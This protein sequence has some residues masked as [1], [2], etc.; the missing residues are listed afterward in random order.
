MEYFIYIFGIAF[1]VLLIAAAAVYPFDPAKASEVLKKGIVTISA[2]S[3]LPFVIAHVF[4][5]AWFLMLLILLLS[6]PIAYWLKKVNSKSDKH[7][8]STR[9][10]ERTPLL[11]RREE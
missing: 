10:A 4:E 9:G 1:A 7:Q 8:P 3:I 2:I 6:S 11:P 5:A